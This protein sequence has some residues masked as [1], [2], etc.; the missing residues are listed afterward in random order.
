MRLIA[1][2]LLIIC[3]Y[4]R[5]QC[6]NKMDDNISAAVLFLHEENFN[7]YKHICIIIIIIDVIGILKFS[8]SHTLNH[9]Y[10]LTLTE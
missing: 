7:F 10:I 3:I 6:F 9:Y 5:I 2:Y 4:E 1:L 8:H